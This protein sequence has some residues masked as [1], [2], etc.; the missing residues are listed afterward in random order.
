MPKGAF[1]C[2]SVRASFELARLNP[3]ENMP[4]VEPRISPSNSAESFQFGA[5]SQIAA[6]HP[7][8]REGQRILNFK[9]CFVK[10][11]NRK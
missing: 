11:P 8:Y 3:G 1:P 5:K 6:Y 9:N 10:F 2:V 4:A 7:V